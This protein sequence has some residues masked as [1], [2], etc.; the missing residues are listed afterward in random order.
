MR[1]IIMLA[2]FDNTAVGVIGVTL[3]RFET[4]G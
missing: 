2:K 3:K 4:K 1:N